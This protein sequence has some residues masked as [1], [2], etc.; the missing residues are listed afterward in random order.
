M[1][2]IYDFIK[3]INN[4]SITL[5]IIILNSLGV[6]L[7][8]TVTAWIGI[9]YV[10]KET[11]ELSK[12]TFSREI[13]DIMGLMSYAN[14]RYE[15]GEI[16][17][18]EA[19]ESV[20]RYVL[21][22][23]NANGV[24]NLA[25]SKLFDRNAD[26]VVW[27]NDQNGTV[28][29]NTYDEGKN[30]WDM[31]VNG[32]FV[33][34]E[35][36]ANPNKTGEL[37]SEYWKNADASPKMWWAYTEFY[38]P[39]GWIV[40]TGGLKSQLYDARIR[41]LQ[42][43][44]IA[45]TLL[46]M[47]FTGVVTYFLIRKISDPIRDG[48]KLAENI[49]QGD[50]SDR[51]S[52]TFYDETGQLAES[53]NKMSD[54]LA[55]KTEFAE[56][57][58]QG[59]L[60]ADFEAI[61][62][63]DTL[64]LALLAMRESLLTNQQE[65]YRRNRFN[66]NLAKFDD[67]LRTYSHDL[68]ILA[69]KLILTIVREMKAVQGGLF[70]VKEDKK[71]QKYL[72][73]T[74]CFAYD[75]KKYKTKKILPNEGLVGQTYLEKKNIYMTRIPNDYVHVTSGL[76]ETNPNCILLIPLMLNQEVLGVLELASFQK[77]EPYEVEFLEKLGEHIAATYAGIQNAAQTKNLLLISQAQEQELRTREEEMR[78]NM[79]ELQST[80]EQMRRKEK[81]MNRVL[82]QASKKEN[83]IT[84]KLQKANENVT[85]YEHILDS[86]HLP[87]AV[88]DPQMNPIF[89]NET[90]AKRFGIERIHLFEHLDQIRQDLDKNKT[91]NTLHISLS[92]IKDRKGTTAGFVE[93]IWNESPENQV[94][95]DEN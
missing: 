67:I 9:E 68:Q 63:K 65:T 14:E 79:E 93:I 61:S 64:G 22:I 44:F 27:A 76:G 37:F 95:R 50:V 91:E 29:M 81:A 88:T 5:K 86:I 26:I 90:M 49:A 58:R 19:Q 36:W 48:V 77:Y 87:I 89:I 33:M 56:Q 73:L 28:V 72:E 62:E 51:L 60:T 20:R 4:I 53:L 42:A 39:W 7:V 92:E 8:S 34:R 47:I 38:A 10:R 57:I 55:Q 25:T 11:E 66:E 94:I 84:R 59:N 23:K 16:S 69:D 24:R 18:S 12:K 75:R 32:R 30:L 21:G 3:N 80:Q 6:L 54:N 70:F 82:D 85:F 78:Q 45:I 13:H 52:Y 1:E 71:Q 41:T 15:R 2:K 40:G 74:A 17:L 35:T 83:K 46:L 43:E 31:K